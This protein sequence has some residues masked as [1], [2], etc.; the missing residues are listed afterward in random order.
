MG[1][2]YGGGCSVG[3]PGGEE[4][5]CVSER[6]V[7]STYG[8]VVGVGSVIGV[9]LVRRDKLCC[10]GGAVEGRQIHVGVEGGSN[11]AICEYGW[12]SYSPGKCGKCGN[13]V[14]EC[15]NRRERESEPKNESVLGVRGCKGIAGFGLEATTPM[16]DGDN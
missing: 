6:V 14:G 13:K 5:S 12:R 9:G 1:I 11:D 8:V 2:E 15:C 10:D 7:Q 16:G 3:R 4:S